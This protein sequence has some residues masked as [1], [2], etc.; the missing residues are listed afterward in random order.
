[1]LTMVFRSKYFRK[2]GV[3][4]L[5][6]EDSVHPKPTKTDCHVGSDAKY[7]AETALIQGEGLT[8]L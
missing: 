4:Y 5:T 3:T 2:L 1:M 7:I 8:K 6:F